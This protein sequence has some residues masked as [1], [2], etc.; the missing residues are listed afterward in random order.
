MSSNKTDL[1]KELEKAFGHD[2]DGNPSDVGDVEASDEE[3]QENIKEKLESRKMELLSVPSEFDDLPEKNDMI[4]DYLYT[5]NLLYT[6]TGKM[7]TSL[8]SAIFLAMES[9][10]PRIFEIIKGIGDT[11]K[12]LSKDIMGL[13]KQYKEIAKL[14]R[15]LD[16]KKEEDKGEGDFVGGSRNIIKLLQD[17]E[18]NNKDTG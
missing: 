4:R 17:M 6:L 15:D 18:K 8:E 2:S 13:Q 9:E 11:C 1:T 16:G 3:I 12:D 10:H 5:R 7:T 14:A